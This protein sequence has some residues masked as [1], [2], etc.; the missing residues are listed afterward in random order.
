MSIARPCGTYDKT[1]AQSLAIVRTRWQWV[2]L[3]VGLVFLFS[4]PLWLSGRWLDFVTVTCI[5]LIAVQGLNL[6]TG[7]CGQISLGQSALMAVGAYTSAVLTAKLGL[8]F[9]IAL[10]LS[11]LSAGAVGLIFGLPSLRVKGF[12]LAMATLAA[13]FIIPALIINPLEPFTGGARS[14]RV[15]APEIAG[16]VCNNPPTIFCIVVPIAVLMTF[17]AKNIARTGIGRAFVAIRDNDLAA[18]VAGIDIFRYKLL[19]FFVCSVY[20][21]IAGCLWAHWVRA[22][23][24]EHFTLMDS[25]WFLGMVVVGGMGST[26]GAV[27]GTV[28]LRAIDELIKTLGMFLSGVFPDWGAMLQGALGPM[29]FGL[30]IMLFLIFEPRG[31]AHLWEVFKISY[32][33]RPFAY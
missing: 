18:E 9:W 24:P 13:Q 32:R 2:L 12:Y 14:L 19:A 7:Y 8:S 16:I 25:I 4:M 3:A 29:T 33:L 20:A 26:A 10:P 22:L 17:F 5:T 1:Y 28:F 11:A 31:L 6:L 30:V 15:P 21:G 27:F 23:N